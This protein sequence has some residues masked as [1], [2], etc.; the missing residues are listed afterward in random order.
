MRR[1][2]AVV[3]FCLA[4]CSASQNM[5]AGMPGTFMYDCV[6][7]KDGVVPVPGKP[8]EECRELEWKAFDGVADAFKSGEGCNRGSNCYYRV[9]YGL[10]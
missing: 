2:I 4:G 6:N 7:G 1:L 9:R 8:I 3:A 10:Y 5:A